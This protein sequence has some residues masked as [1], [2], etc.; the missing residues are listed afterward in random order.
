MT[1]VVCSITELLLLNTRKRKDR[2]GSITGKGVGAADLVGAVVVSARDFGASLVGTSAVV[3]V[4][5]ERL[6]AAED[7]DVGLAF[8]GAAVLEMLGWVARVGY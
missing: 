4:L 3:D 8:V 1:E 6:R 7:G 2:V 5:R